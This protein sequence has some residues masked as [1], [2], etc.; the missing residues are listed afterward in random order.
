MHSGHSEFGFLHFPQN[1]SG[2]WKGGFCIASAILH[3]SGPSQFPFEIGKV[4]DLFLEFRVLS[5]ISWGGGA[6]GELGRVSHKL[7]WDITVSFLTVKVA[8]EIGKVSNSV[9]ECKV[10]V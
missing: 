3:F 10:L 1:S 5:L 6:P 2:T 7:C 8:L 9:L 4:S